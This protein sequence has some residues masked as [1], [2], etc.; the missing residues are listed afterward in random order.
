MG[1]PLGQLQE[2]FS[3]HNNASAANRLRLN[4][5]GECTRERK[6]YL[7]GIR[8]SLFKV[9]GSKIILGVHQYPQ[10]LVAWQ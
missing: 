5:L 9:I 8:V 7:L 1:G 3:T 4:D 2:G 6:L 10:D